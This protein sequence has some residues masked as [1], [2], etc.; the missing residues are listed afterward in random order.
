MTVPLAALPNAVRV[1][2][3]D[4][5]DGLVSILGD[6]LVALWVYGAVTF[7]DRPRRLGDVDTHAVVGSPVAPRIARAIDELHES[8]G[9]E[10]GVEWDSWYVFERDMPSAELP[11]HA[12]RENLVDRAW[13]LHRAH[14]LAGQYVLLHGRAPSDLVRAPTWAELEDALRSEL[15]FVDEMVRRGPRDAEH[16]A[17]VV[18]NGCRI[19]YSVRTRD[20][21]VSKR[22][23]ARWALDHLPHSWHEAILAAGRAYDARLGPGDA[24]VL[25][26][27]ADPIV[28]AV[29]A[30]LA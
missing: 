6:D 19:V 2:C 11:P 29:Q 13:A 22:A 10:R 18:W 12:F 30:E 3:G 27:A 21:V 5:R 28:A 24:A 9:R 17:F 7:E 20:V 14:W 16:A 4:L 25:W 1:A 15:R 26:A 8:I 23:A